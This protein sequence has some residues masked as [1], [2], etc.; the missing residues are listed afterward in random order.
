MIF[1]SE[2]LTPFFLLRRLDANDKENPKKDVAELENNPYEYMT[3][4]YDLLTNEPESASI[5]K[6][7]NIYMFF[8]LS[9]I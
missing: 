4:V 9:T 3:D 8:C 6:E 7:V 1:L 5:V 2:L